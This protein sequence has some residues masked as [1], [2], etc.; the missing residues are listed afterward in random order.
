MS[1]FHPLQTE[2]GSA[3]S[4]PMATDENLA[5]RYYGE[6]LST[7]M[8]LKDDLDANLA[9]QEAKDLLVELIEVCRSDFRLRFHLDS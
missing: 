5:E 4:R 1:P 7:L 6:M 9:P 2:A 8:G 3:H